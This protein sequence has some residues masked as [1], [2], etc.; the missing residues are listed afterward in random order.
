MLTKGLL[1]E[2]KINAH[3]FF[4]LCTAYRA[5]SRP[6]W[7]F[8]GFICVWILPEAVVNLLNEFV[9]FDGP[10]EGAERGPSGVLFPRVVCRLPVADHP[11]AVETADVVTFFFVVESCGCHL[12]W[13]LCQFYR[14]VQKVVY[15]LFEWCQFGPLCHEVG[16]LCL[17]DQL[18]SLPWLHDIWSPSLSC[19][20]K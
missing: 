16:E 12:P 5:D 8:L 1:R 15:S 7:L 11:V 20:P 6:S 4:D 10:Q 13:P 17:A 2:R 19:F 9:S 14:P 3:T 18:P